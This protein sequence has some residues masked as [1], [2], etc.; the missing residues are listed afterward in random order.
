MHTARATRRRRARAAVGLAL[1]VL[2]GAAAALAGSPALAQDPVTEAPDPPPA[3][4]G[5]VIRVAIRELPPFVERVDDQPTGF[6]VELWEEVAER[7]GATTE[8]VVVDTVE[9]QLDA[10]AEGRADVAGTAISV[11]RDREAVVDFSYPYFDSGLQILAPT[12]DDVGVRGAL[13]NL[14]DADVVSLLVVFVVALVVVGVVVWLLERRTN[15]EFA[16]D[17]ALRGAGHGIWWAIVTV[18]TVGYGDRVTRR[19]SSRVIAAVWIVFGLVFLAQFTAT[20]TT[21]LT[22]DELASD[23]RGPD[24]LPGRD[25]VTVEGTTAAAWLD[26]EGISA[27]GLDDVDEVVR[28]V[29]DGEADVAVYD[30]PVLAY[31]AE[32]LGGERVLVVGAP[33]TFETYAFALPQGSELSDAL[34]RAL[35]DAIEDGAYRRLRQAWFPEG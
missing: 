28:A 24:D 11:T 20:V 19:A 4:E 18:S 16:D 9:D 21:N 14:G 26:E 1:G 29:A 35:L 30:G 25:V 7:L 8:W 6:T 15:P 34:D 2:L 5:Q 22:V 33:L 12:R 13:A 17:G 3:A 32:V 10:V 23:I 31:E 27:R